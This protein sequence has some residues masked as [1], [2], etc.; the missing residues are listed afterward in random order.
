MRRS[1]RSGHHARQ[2]KEFGQYRIRVNAIS[3][4]L[5]TTDFS[6]LAARMKA[7]TK[8]LKAGHCARG[9]ATRN[10][11]RCLFLASDL[12]T[13]ITGTTL[14]INGGAHMN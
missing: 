10:R 6:R 11:R 2:A 13:Y 14:D 8:P 12:S 4:G 9:A 3:P 5:I 1:R 7:R